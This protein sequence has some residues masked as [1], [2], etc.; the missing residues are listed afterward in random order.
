M[1]M[2]DNTNSCQFP[3]QA[4]RLKLTRLLKI[5]PLQI[6][7]ISNTLFAGG[8]KQLRKERDTYKLSME[9]VGEVGAGWRLRAEQAEE[10]EKGLQQTIEIVLA[11]KSSETGDPLVRNLQ[12]RELLESALAS[13][14]SGEKPTG[15]VSI[16]PDDVSDEEAERFTEHLLGGSG[17]EGGGA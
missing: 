2:R 16:V 8:T 6:Q 14:D 17:A 7:T 3:L 4:D 1:G 13:Q 10:R 11:L 5:C 12:A 9:Q 15:P